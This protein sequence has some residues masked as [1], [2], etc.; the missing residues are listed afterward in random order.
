MEEPERRIPIKLFVEMHGPGS[1]ESP[2]GRC[3]GFELI[4]FGV[5]VNDERREETTNV[6]Y[7]FHEEFNSHI[8]RYFGL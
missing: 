2:D 7:G 3:D 8:K 4:C 5:E 1:Y 6:H